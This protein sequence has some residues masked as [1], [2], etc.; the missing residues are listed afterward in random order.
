MMGN[1]PGQ[2]IYPIPNRVLPVNGMPKLIVG[3]ACHLAATL[4]HAANILANG[5]LED[6]H[7][8]TDPGYETYSANSPSSTAITG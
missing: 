2:V 4:S 6:S 3:A 5:G 7:I 8:S 1:T